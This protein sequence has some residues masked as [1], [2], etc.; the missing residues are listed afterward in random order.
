MQ[1]T[2]L[3]KNWKNFSGRAGRLEFLLINLICV[4]VLFLTTLLSIKVFEIFFGDY[5]QNFHYYINSNEYKETVLQSALI[6]MFQTGSIN[7]TTNAISQIYHNYENETL[8]HFILSSLSFILFLPFLVMLVTGSIRRLHDIGTFGW[9]VLIVA[10]P[11]YLF[12][13]S[14]I[15][16]A[17]LLFLFFKDGQ[18]FYNKYG[19]DPKNPNAPIPLELPQ[20]SDNLMKFETKVLN[21]IESIK[22]LLKS[23]ITKIMNKL[24]NKEFLCL[25]VHI[26]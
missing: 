18:S 26:L 5:H 9:W 10:C 8:K 2:D 7:Q 15:L 21:M 12:L 1:I 25:L 16:I 11:I 20:G 14:W 23:Y 13:D 22:V 4:V 17:P 24:K 6:E 19:P 3:F